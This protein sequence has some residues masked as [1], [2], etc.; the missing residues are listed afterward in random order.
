MLKKIPY[1][2]S[3]TFFV[4][5]GC[6]LLNPK[7][8][9]ATN[10]SIIYKLE[11]G[12]A[13]EKKDTF[14]DLTFEQI[15]IDLDS[16]KILLDSARNWISADELEL[17]IRLTSISGTYFM[18]EGKHELALRYYREALKESLKTNLKHNQ[19]VAYSNLGGIY[20]ELGKTDSASIFLNEGLLIANQLGDVKF[21]ANV[22]YDLAWVN[23]RQNLSDI[24]LE[25]IQKAEEYSLELND[26][27]QL[28]NIYNAYFSLYK[29]NDDFETALKYSK[30]AIAIA[31]RNQ[32][33]ASIL[34]NLYNNLGVAYW[35]VLNEYD[36]SRHYLKKANSLYEHNSK[37]TNYYLSNLINFGGME[38]QSGNPQKGLDYLDEALA[39]VYPLE[40]KYRLGLCAVRERRF[41]KALFK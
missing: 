18:H 29:G 9:Q 33:S 34:A 17:F 21:L 11:H 19:L 6:F 38:I 12:S 26:S 22:N 31:K 3:L 41:S 16:A 20:I 8:S 24:A 13:F 4:L 35:Q 30:K 36:S 27:L 40:D 1:F 15:T 28:V 23:I 2:V 7:T 37:A 5:L 14:L 10:D 25:Y 32:K 39:L